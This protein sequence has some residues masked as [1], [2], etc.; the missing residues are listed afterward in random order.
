MAHCARLGAVAY[1]AGGSRGFATTRAW[2]W[3]NPVAGTFGS[4]TPEIQE[5][6]LE[7]PKPNSGE[8]TSVAVGTNHSAFVCDGEVYSWG[9]KEYGV[10]GH[11][12]VDNRNPMKVEFD[13]VPL[14]VSLGDY[15]SS[16]L[17]TDGKLYN[18]GWGGSFLGGVGALGLGSKTGTDLPTFVD[19]LDDI[20]V[21]EKNWKENFRGAPRKAREN[22]VFISKIYVF[23]YQKLDFD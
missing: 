22:Y 20:K 15:H 11:S 2:R 4:K 3:G 12:G 14:A 13:G 6:P 16:I 1:R 5:T 10:L 19:T 7:I 8:F 9:S 21:A 18:W 17:T 23:P